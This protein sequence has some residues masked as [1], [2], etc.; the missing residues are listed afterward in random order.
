VNVTRSVAPFASST[1]FPQLSQTRTVFRAN[2]VLLEPICQTYC[3]S[4]SRP[5]ARPHEF[6]ASAG[7]PRWF[8]RRDTARPAQG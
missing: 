7:N 8:A 5:A 6:A 2:E 1:S 3:R 4:K